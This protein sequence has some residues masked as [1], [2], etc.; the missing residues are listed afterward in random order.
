MLSRSAIVP[1]P[2]GDELVCAYND[3]D[4]TVDAWSLISEKKL[5]TQNLML[6]EP[7]LDICSFPKDNNC[8]L[9]PCLSESKLSIVNFEFH[10]NNS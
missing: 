3:R 2:R 6:A 5:S 10:S 9:I 1:T 4:S 7:V 8:I